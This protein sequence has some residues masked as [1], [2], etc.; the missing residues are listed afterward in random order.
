LAEGSGGS[1]PERRAGKGGALH[2]TDVTHL[3]RPA[4][5]STS[6][7]LHCGVELHLR[8]DRFVTD[9]EDIRCKALPLR[10]ASFL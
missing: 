8:H 10:K 6:F 4:A 1:H 7:F 3:S 9:W 5:K 2:Q